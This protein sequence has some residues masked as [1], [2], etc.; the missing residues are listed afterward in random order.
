MNKDEFTEAINK[1][2]ELLWGIS[3]REFLCEAI[4]RECGVG[5]RK[6]F[7]DIFNFKE[8]G[9]YC[10]G[11]P[12]RRSNQVICHIALEMFYQTCLSFKLHE[13]LER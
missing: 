3:E 7:K 9:E 12:W 11:K 4:C 13:E 2:D 1:T 8:Y 6:L 5:A 10:F